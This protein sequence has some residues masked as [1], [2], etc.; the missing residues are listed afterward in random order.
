VAYQRMPRRIFHDVMLPA[1]LTT[2][3]AGGCSSWGACRRAVAPAHA[4]CRHSPGRGLDLPV[5][6]RDAY[7]RDKFTWELTTARKV[8]GEYFERYPNIQ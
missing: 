1:E 7:I 6:P 8:A 2:L 5:M 3:N 4:S